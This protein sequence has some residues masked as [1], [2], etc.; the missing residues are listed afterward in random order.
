MK[1]DIKYNQKVRFFIVGPTE[2]G[3]GCGDSLWVVCSTTKRCSFDTIYMND[4]FVDG[5]SFGDKDEAVAFL[6]DK[7]IKRPYVME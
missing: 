7:G 1:R 5:D 6:K 2:I 3:K 4:W